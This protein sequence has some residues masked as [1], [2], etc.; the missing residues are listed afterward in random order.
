METDGSAREVA[1]R[2]PKEPAEAGVST[3]EVAANPP[4]AVGQILTLPRVEVAGNVWNFLGARVENL[5]RERYTRELLAYFEPRRG[6]RIPDAERPA[7]AEI[8]Y[9]DA[10][11][12]GLGGQEFWYT[13][14][15]PVAYVQ[16][17]IPPPPDRHNYV[18]LNFRKPDDVVEIKVWLN[19]REA[20]VERY[21]QWRGPAG[22]FTFYVDGSRTGL[23]RGDNVLKVYVRYR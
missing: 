6:P 12:A 19:D 9:P 18:S 7:G 22:A 17:Y 2:F 14:R 20:S 15:F 3:W 11:P 16:Q 5:W 23:K 13:S 10:P 1:V 8:R 21:H 4:P